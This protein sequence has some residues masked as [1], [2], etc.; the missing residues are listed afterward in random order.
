MNRQQRCG[1]L[2]L[3]AVASLLVLL[4]RNRSHSSIAALEDAGMRPLWL[5]KRLDAERS[6]IRQERDERVDEFEK[7]LSAASEDEPNSEDAG[8]QSKDS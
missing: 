3:G 7:Q 2:L 4:S 1:G 8:D 5:R 6:K